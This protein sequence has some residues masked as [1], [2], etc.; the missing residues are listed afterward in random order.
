MRDG[1]ASM[2]DNSARGGEIFF[3]LRQDR[4][5]AGFFAAV[6]LGKTGML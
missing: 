5:R 1:I 4:R 3:A 6:P 2:S